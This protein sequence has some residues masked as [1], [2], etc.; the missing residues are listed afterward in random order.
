M[1]PQVRKLERERAQH[2]LLLE[3]LQ[4]RHQAD[5]ELIENA[6]RY[7]C[8]GPPGLPK[9]PGLPQPCARG[10][11]SGGR[12]HL[13]SP[14]AGC[15]VGRSRIKVLETSYQQREERLRRENEELSA[16]YLSHCQAAEQARAELTTQHQRRLAAA[17][18]EKDQEVERLRQLQR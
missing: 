18:L 3:T 2:K 5:L 10:G 11:P 17:E 13:L 15:S 6:H 9:A 12:P 14:T 8:P 4:Q 1:L 16:Q 7:P